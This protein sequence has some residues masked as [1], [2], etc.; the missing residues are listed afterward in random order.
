METDKNLIRVLAGEP[1][2]RIPIWMMRQA[3]RYLPEYRD[4]RKQAGSFLD[5]CYNSKL[6]SEVTLQPI[7]R[8]HFDAAILFADILLI[9]DALGQKVAFEENKGPVLEP[10]IVEDKLSN[11]SLDNCSDHLAPIFETVDRVAGELPDD[12]ALIGFCGAPWTVATYMIAGIG[13][14]DQKPARLAAYR[15][16]EWFDALIDLLVVSSIDYLN[17]Q[18]SA[19]CEVVQIFD[20]WAG[21]LPEDEF[22]KWCIDPV[23]RI[24][25]GVKKVHPEVPVIGFPR[26]CGTF[27]EI[28]AAQIGADA[29]SLDTSVSLDWTK[30]VLQEKV[31]VQGNL[32]PLAVVA[33]GSALDIRVNRILKKLSS[34]PF[35]FNLGHGLVP[36]TPVDNVG[37]VVDLVRDFRVGTAS[38]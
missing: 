34:A 11:L 16:P 17:A 19:G 31:V 6:A 15:H 3:G 36:E 18:I 8:F 25:G 9:P 38:Q 32:D 22:L 37:R 23:R 29:L 5:L 2:E 24:V 4:T 33:G 26:G 13:T 10:L 12:V 1:T 20:S 30:Q 27:Y 28:A 21:V 14:S 7:R 35:V